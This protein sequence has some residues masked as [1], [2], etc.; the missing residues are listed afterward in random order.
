MLMAVVLGGYLVPSTARGP[1]RE[2]GLRIRGDAVLEIAPNEELLCNPGGEEIYDFRDCILTPGF[3]NG[4]MHMYG[5]LSHGIEVPAAPTGFQS[6]LDDFWWP[7][8]ENRL[9]HDMIRASTAWACLEM[10][11]SGITTFCDILEAPY[12]IPGALAVEK[13]VVERAGMRGLLSFEACERVSPENGQLGLEENARLI[14]EGSSDFVGGLMSV[15]TTF[16]CSPSFLKAADGMAR[17]LG[18]LFHMHLSESSYEPGYCL[19]KYGKRP[20]EVYRDLGILGPHVVASQGVDLSPEEIELLKEHEVKLVHMPLS[21][22]EVGGGIAPVPLLLEQGVTVGLGTDGYINNFFEVMRGA[23]L[24]H[25]A[26]QKNPGVMPA[27]TVWA[28][29]TEMGARALGRPD[30]GR[31]EPGCKAD[32]VAVAADTPT[33]VNEKNIF[34]QLVL[35]R[36]PENIR[37]VMVG[38]RLVAA[39]GRVLTLNEQEVRAQVK[40]AAL[41]LWAFKGGKTG[42]GSS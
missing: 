6:F 14:K 29:A 18:A 42:H 11:R 22:C 1:L 26:A 35:Y 37:A 10:L 17:S 3:I 36:N 9:D 20:V 8:V 33:P 30:L 7:L 24:L 25:K 34:D 40:E 5:V 31:L 38:G 32:L 23:F 39:A 16:T 13:K 15:H 21:N 4:H 28:M 2:W 19:E 12:A 27:S 41:R